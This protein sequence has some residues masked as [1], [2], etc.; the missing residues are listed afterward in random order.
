MSEIEMSGVEE[1]TVGAEETEV[2]D[3]S[4]EIT[5][6]AEET[7]VAEPSDDEKSPSDAAFAKMRRKN[8]ELERKLAEYDEA[9]SYVFEGE[10]DERVVKA[11]AFGEG[12]T[13][14]QVKAERELESLK[15]EKERLEEELEN[16]E[17]ER[18]M[19]EDLEI[20][21]KIDPSVKT[22][23]DLDPSFFQMIATGYVS[24]E[25]AYYACKAKADR[26]KVK[27]PEP[28]GEVKTSPEAKDYFT[29]DEVEA[30][31]KADVKKNFDAIRRSMTKW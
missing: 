4:E 6:G 23:L 18:R 16:V 2:A 7:E 1:T 9:L 26:G 21:K 20:I 11:K 31:S 22:L 27:T 19:A 12:K 29:R 10:G 3:Q 24:A 30:M 8:E 13:E 17:V 28:V 25:E 15:S 5:E 14:E